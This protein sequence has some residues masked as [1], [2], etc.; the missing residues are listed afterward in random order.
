MPC[1][2]W[3][4][5]LAPPTPRHHTSDHLNEWTSQ[6]KWKKAQTHWQTSAV[7]AVNKE[8]RRCLRHVYRR[9]FDS[10]NSRFIC[11]QQHHPSTTFQ[12]CALILLFVI[13]QKRYSLWEWTIDKF[14]FH[15]KKKQTSVEG[16]WT[17]SKQQETA[18]PTPL[19]R[20]LK[21]VFQ[22]NLSK[23]QFKYL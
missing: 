10:T 22:I 1:Q 9:A 13:L 12:F 5:S 11:H 20:K 6:M 3:L 18:A 14:T 7:P 19:W 17:W 8:R 4:N 15:E 2:T 16:R 21:R 23:W